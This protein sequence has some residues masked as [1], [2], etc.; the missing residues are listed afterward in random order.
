MYA[1]LNG[2]LSIGLRLALVA[3]I[4]V[5]ASAVSAVLLANYGKT[6]IDFSMKEK[7][8]TIYNGNIWQSLQSGRPEAAAHTQYDPMF[9]SADAH[10]AFAKV[11]AWNDRVN[12]AMAL[13]VAVADGSNLTLDPDLDSYYAMDAS[14][15]KLPNLLAMSL[16]LK[17]AIALPADTPDRHTTVAMALDRFETAAAAAYSSVDTSMKNNAAGATKTALAPSRTTLQQIT[18]AMSAAAHADLDGHPSDFA[19]AEKP[20]NA[21]LDKAWV[22]TN[23]ELLR[24]IEV[25]IG[26]LYRGLIVNIL[27][28][29]GLI[30]VSLFLTAVITLGLSRRFK[31]LGEAMTKLN[32]GD[33]TVEVPYLDD[34]NETGHIAETLA[35]L[36]KGLIQREAEEKQREAD[37]IA[38]AEAQKKAEAEAQTR[39][40]ALVVGTFGEGL[41][42]LA[43]ENL[44]FRLEADLPP[45]YRALQDNFNHAIAV[46]EQNQKDRE[47]ASKQRQRDR[48]SSAAAQ[49][50]AEEEAKARSME[51][52]VGSF[53]KAL[54]ELADRNL[55]YRM[56]FDLPEGYRQ[57]QTDFNR[58]ME[59]LAAAMH[60]IDKCAGGIAASASEI[61]S[62]SQDL[63]QRTERQAA[64]LEETAAAMEQITATVGKSAENAKEASNRADNAQS[65][66]ERGNAV[67][68]QTLEAMQGIAKSSNEISQIIGVIDEIAFQTN[69]LA[70]NAGVEAARAGEAGKG[71]AVVASEVRSLAQRSAEAAKKIKTL[72]H[73]SEDQ[74]DTG[75]KLVEES[76]NALN[77]IVD[78]IH[79]I[80]GLMSDIASA[81]KEQ[82]TALGEINSAV[83]HM[84]Q[85]TQQNAAMVEQST[86]A[87][88]SLADDAKE[89]SG[90]VSQFKTGGDEQPA[91]AD[92]A[93]NAA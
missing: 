66:A 43:K 62:A 41:E 48:V 72:I 19:A 37:R 84:D 29:V 25:R 71:F 20:F 63:S 46:F 30:A 27:I 15:V 40:E 33:K 67:A 58:S 76:S 31:A 54:K 11:K 23:N 5:I 65:D 34:R 81:Q 38:A 24:L 47:E 9:G 82:S 17:Q 60:E 64:S 16:R 32:A 83:S 39:S 51:M 7:Y 77:R 22:A 1:F 28:V 75:V 13:I 68:K 50:R 35:N 90:M 8:G 89:L 91:A 10:T 87:S 73:A 92:R 59:E 12:A 69:L 79:K 52:V 4:F 78:D 21:A 88:R 55:S 93:R 57:L 45:A 14:T 3:G 6:N 86:A 80:T 61:S 53:G 42:A 18:D 26:G 2:R 36:K 44:A 74:V 85:T 70:L 49:K 56:N